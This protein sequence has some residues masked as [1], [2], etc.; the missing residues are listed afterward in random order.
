MSQTQ[1]I[2][3]VPATTIEAT[4]EST[5]INNGHIYVTTDT[6]R[7]YVDLNS[8]RLLIDGNIYL[9]TELQRTS[10]I[11]P[12]SNKL[13]IVKETGF[14]YMYINGEWKL[15]GGVSNYEELTNLPKINNV[16]LSGELD[17]SDIGAQ[18]AVD[19]T[20]TTTNKTISGAIN[21]I[22][23]KAGASL[24]RKEVHRLTDYDIVYDEAVGTYTWTINHSFGHSDILTVLVDSTTK[25]TVW[26]EPKSI[27]NTTVVYSSTHEFT[28]DVTAILL[29]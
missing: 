27:T 6:K 17:L 12:L 23:S 13:Y 9:E 10:I 29:G 11:A 26:G 21:E 7:L 5:P 2:M 1:S 14:S 25:G 24:V 22:N 16:V 28:R 19:N 4:L 18:P 8:S 3:F 20:L 15:V